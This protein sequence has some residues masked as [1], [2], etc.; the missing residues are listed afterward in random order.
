MNIKLLFENFHKKNREEIK[1]LITQFLEQDFFITFPQLQEE[2]S[3]VITGSVASGFQDKNSDLD[4]TLF[5]QSKELL[6]KYGPFI[7]N[8]FKGEKGEAKKYPLELHGG[9]LRLFENIESELNLWEKDWM[10]REVADAIIV[11]DPLNNFIKLQQK[12]SWYPAEVFEEKI[13]WL[14][15][16]S[17]FLIFDRYKIGMERNSL[18]YTEKIKLKIL[19]LFM[20]ILIMHNHKY[21]KSEKHLE[22]D[23]EVFGNIS[24]EIKKLTGSILLERKSSEI[25][26]LLCMLRKDIENIL[27]DSKIIIKEDENYWFRLRPTYRVE[28]G[29]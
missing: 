7:V 3:V 8:E 23:V 14:F 13:N 9:N 2:I 12:Y 11:H 20:T 19:G 18:Y 6:E 27:V 25:F 24:M 1:E 15:A 16:E 17:T 4:F 26:N 10:L 28:L 29:K 5:F 21:P 22:R